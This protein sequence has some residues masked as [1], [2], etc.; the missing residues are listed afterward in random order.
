MDLNR[1]DCWIGFFSFPFLFFSFFFSFF[2][3]DHYLLPGIRCNGN[4]RVADAFRSFS[5][6][7]QRDDRFLSILFP[8]LFLVS[9]SFFLFFG[10]LI[11]MRVPVFQVH[12]CLYR[13]FPGK[14]LPGLN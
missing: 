9:L 6:S 3:F 8:P 11:A 12:T 10:S 7:P 4:G 14:F 5:S 13:Y 1:F 2:F